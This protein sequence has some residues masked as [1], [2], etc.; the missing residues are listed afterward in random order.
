MRERN[1]NK[2]YD[3][4][5]V[6]A[7]GAG[8]P[9]AARLSEH[10]DRSI[11]L[12]EAGPVPSNAGEFPPELLDAAT[13]QGAIPGHA[14]NWSFPAHLTPE[15]PYSIARG[16]ILGG[17][18]SISG[19]Y[20]VRAQKRDFEQWSSGGNHEWAWDKALPFYRK[21]EKDLQYGDSAVHGDR[22]PMPVWR[23][24]QSHPISKAFAAAC[25]DLGYLIEPDK[26]D[27]SHP[28]YG[29]LPTNTLQGQR[30][31]VG[32]AYVNPIRH[33]PN[34]TVQGYSY[35]RRVLF[36]GRKAAGVE[37]LVDGGISEVAAKEVVLCAGAIKTPHILLLSGLGPRRE[38]DRWGIP[39]IADLPGVGRNFSDHPSL[40]INWKSEN[41]AT[42]PGFTPSAAG[43]LNFTASGSP[44]TGDLEILPLLNSMD[45]LLNGN[46]QATVG[47]H[48][49]LTT[50][51]A[52]TSRGQITLRSCDPHDPPRLDFNYLS[53]ET[54]RR[55]MRE[56][57]LVAVQL[58]ETKA[59]SGIFKELSDLSKKV[60]SNQV[61]LDN[62]I[63]SNIGTN[64]H[65]CGSARFG[66]A[67]DPESVVDQYGKVHRVTGLRIADLSI[68]PTAPSRGPAATAVLIGERIADFINRS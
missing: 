18:T 43:V 36:D 24:P 45:H 10:P 7:G 33:R 19:T 9:L 21:L 23:H 35:V 65:L 5:V 50:L 62:W 37:I 55:R 28:G 68:L 46:R 25:N 59:F 6:G 14:N 26:N 54:D 16:R 27:Q 38:L 20:F 61:L 56:V 58:L 29:P 53:T 42:G 11:L 34:L 57:V 44:H 64:F 1:F 13:L 67:K 51:Q 39:S 49:F 22:G 12:L 41:P 15:R 8:A 47:K 32:T 40:A 3:V 4:I 60:L 2:T 48:A 52:E 31:N 63:A 17:S 30:I 66:S